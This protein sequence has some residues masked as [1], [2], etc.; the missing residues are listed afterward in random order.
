MNLYRDEAGHTHF[1]GDKDINGVR[2][3]CNPKGYPGE[4][5]AWKPLKVTVT[6]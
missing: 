1:A 3:I 4:N 6:F 5:P 2:C